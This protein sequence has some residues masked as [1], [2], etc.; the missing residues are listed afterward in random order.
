MFLDVL[1]HEIRPPLYVACYFLVPAALPYVVA[2]VAAPWNNGAS[3][4][5]RNGLGYFERLV[6]LQGGL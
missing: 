6:S 5:Q 4:T 1:K 2:V 3:S